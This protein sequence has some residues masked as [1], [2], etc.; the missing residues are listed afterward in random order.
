MALFNDVWSSRHR[1]SQII[2]DVDER[3]ELLKCQRQYSQVVYKPDS[4]WPEL[5]RSAD[6]WFGNG[7]R[8]ADRPW[9]K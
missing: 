5:L 4:E 6:P 2:P 1:I 7:I 9:S 8:S 3:I